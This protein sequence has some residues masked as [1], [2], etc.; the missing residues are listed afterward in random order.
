M[1]YRVVRVII[2]D[3]KECETPSPYALHG[4]GESDDANA[5]ADGWK[6]YIH[7]AGRKFHIC[8]TCLAAG[9]GE[10]DLPYLI[11]VDHGAPPGSQRPDKP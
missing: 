10:Y 6:E 4:Q 5:E 8:P 1:S 2:C 9:K 3:I 11:V 7:P